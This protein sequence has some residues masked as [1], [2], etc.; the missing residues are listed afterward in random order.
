MPEKTISNG[1]EAPQTGLD[2][3]PQMLLDYNVECYS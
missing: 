1:F 3:Q 2:R